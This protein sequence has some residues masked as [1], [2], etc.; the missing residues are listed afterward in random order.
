MIFAMN[1]YYPVFERIKKIIIKKAYKSIFIINS[2][3]KNILLIVI[4]IYIKYLL[5]E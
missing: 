4:F 5:V 2:C 3:K 1:N